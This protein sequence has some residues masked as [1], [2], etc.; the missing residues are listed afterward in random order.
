MGSNVPFAGIPIAVCGDHGKL[1]PILDAAVWSEKYIDF[2]M[3]MKMI[4]KMLNNNN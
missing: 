3:M 4:T 1:Q 2:E